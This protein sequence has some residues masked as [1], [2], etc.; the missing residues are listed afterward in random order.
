[1]KWDAE[2]KK[3]LLWVGI[4]KGLCKRKA[5]FT[6]TATHCTKANEQ[7][8]TNRKKFRNHKKIILMILQK[9]LLLQRKKLLL[10][11]VRFLTT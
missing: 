11:V 4:K 5:F 9:K 1:M 3:E 6:A 7:L 8:Q 10:P 2:G